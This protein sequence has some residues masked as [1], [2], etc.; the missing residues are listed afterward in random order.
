MTTDESRDAGRSGPEASGARAGTGSGG[1]TDETGGGGPT[2]GALDRRSFVR[3]IAGD[4]V[5][6]AGRVAGLSG[7]LTGSVLAAA[8]AATEGFRA[9]G[10]PAIAAPTD[11]PAPAAPRPRPTVP[12]RPVPAATSTLPPPLAD[13]DRAVLE[14]ATIGRLAT[15]Q[16]GGPPAVGLARF[17]FLD[18][19]F[20]VPGRSATARTTNLQ[21]DPH[22][23]ITVID[24]DTG[25]ALLAAGTARLVHGAEGQEAA[26]AV[27]GAC[28][29]ELT[30]DWARPDSRGEPI[31]VVVELTRLF[32]RRPAHERP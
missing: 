8:K 31:L 29:I 21:R 15:N 13:A 1:T 12:P 9:L 28:A 32:R 22:A 18:G 20:L 19:A 4:G 17:R 10:G 14:A 26:A 24:P 7:L 3:A 27:L 5:V 11:P 25:D 2:A 23:S 16:P 30:D 6:T